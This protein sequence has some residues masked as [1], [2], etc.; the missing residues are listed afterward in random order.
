M[1]RRS[2]VKTVP[3]EASGSWKRPW[4]SWRAWRTWPWSSSGP[5]ALQLPRPLQNPL[6][7]LTLRLRWRPQPP[8]NRPRRNASWTTSR[9]CRRTWGRRWTTWPSWKRR[10]WRL[11]WRQAAVEEQGQ[12]WVSTT[13]VYTN[14]PVQ[15][16]WITLNKSHILT[17]HVFIAFYL[18]VCYCSGRASWRGEAPA[19]AAD[20]GGWTRMAQRVSQWHTSAVPTEWG[21]TWRHLHQCQGRGVLCAGVGT[22]WG[23]GIYNG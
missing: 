6:P 11:W 12:R 14:L 19:G 5:A 20:T 10:R 9:S 17:L 2:P 16:R 8:R 7:Q 3:L 22:R 15:S 23:M 1:E 4:R 13:V 21:Q 18:L